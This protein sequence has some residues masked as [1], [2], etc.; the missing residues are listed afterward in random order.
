MITSSE[1]TTLQPSQHLT[2]LTAPGLNPGPPL[3]GSEPRPGP[4]ILPRPTSCAKWTSLGEN[5]ACEQM[6]ETGQKG[7]EASTVE[8]WTDGRGQLHLQGHQPPEGKQAWPAPPSSRSW[9]T[10]IEGRCGGQ[11]RL[12]CLPTEQRDQSGTT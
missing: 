12:L 3:M 9:T 7:D 5:P 11:G 8:P 4:C 1:P 10:G 2:A 6:A